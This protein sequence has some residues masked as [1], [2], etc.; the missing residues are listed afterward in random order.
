M[1]EQQYQAPQGNS[2]GTYQPPQGDYSGT[3]QAPGYSGAYQAPQ[4]PA[5]GAWQNPGAA[6]GRGPG[7]EPR[8]GFITF[9]CA[10]IPGGGQMYLGYM[11]RGLSLL[12]LFCGGWWLSSMID[13][14]F[15]FAIVAWMYSFFDT[16]D[17]RGKISTGTAAPDDYVIHF[18]DSGASRLLQK[19]HSLLGWGLIVLGVWAIYESFLYPMVSAF[20]ERFGLYWL[21]TIFRRLPSLLLIALLIG[22]GVWLVR[23]PKERDAAGAEEDLHYYAP[24]PGANSACAAGPAA[25]AAPQAP[26]AAQEPPRQ[27]GAPE[28]APAPRED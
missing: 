22:V 5:Q 1:N 11:K 18:E 28:N 27:A 6:P 20:C 17:L 21:E 16:F 14:L 23:G 10:F 8:S 9:C 12:L 7:R 13:S 3:Y 4:G 2:S 19:R 25:D 26:D 15:V 24:D